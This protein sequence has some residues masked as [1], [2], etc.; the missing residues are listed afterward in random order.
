MFSS[1]QVTINGRFSEF[2]PE[3]PAGEEITYCF[4]ANCGSTVFWKTSRRAGTVCVAVGSFAD[5]SFPM[6]DVSVWESKRLTWIDFD[7]TIERR[8]HD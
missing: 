4:C 2:S 8:Q 1:D 5:E 3:R 7:E 6:P